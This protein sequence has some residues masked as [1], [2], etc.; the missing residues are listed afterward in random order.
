[1][2]ESASIIN[3]NLRYGIY[4][5]A[6]A[7]LSAISFIFSEIGLASYKLPP[8][9]IAFTS[10]VIGGFFLLICY[11][12]GSDLA[13]IR[14]TGVLAPLLI[15]AISTYAVGPLTGFIA[16]ERIGSGQAALLGLLETPFII[17][18]GAIFLKEMLSVWGWVASGLAMI[19]AFVITLDPTA[20]RLTWSVGEFYA[21][22][23]AFLFAAG[24]VASR[25]ALRQLNP[26][27]T[28]GLLLLLG[29]VG[30]GLFLPTAKNG[31]LAGMS[32]T[33]I[34]ILM[35]IGLLRGVTWLLFNSGVKHI[36][37][38]SAAI[39]F[40]P[41]AFFTVAIQ[42]GTAAFIPNLGL[43]IPGNLVLSLTGGLLI[44]IGV[45]L[46]EIRSK[47]AAQED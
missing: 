35:V 17:L 13:I 1:M 39:L 7:L 12:Q 22:L 14:R 25:H 42:G 33:I 10:N 15:S 34:A 19:G 8:V 18:L 11:R 27:W 44:A 46:W 16:L 36:G 26:G 20:F 45:A 47:P 41:Q 9:T 3:G 31:P 24:I 2:S 43:Q 28:S 21:V 6:S 23:S 40:L 32:L 29:S 37:A 4:I 5:V 30:L 38:S